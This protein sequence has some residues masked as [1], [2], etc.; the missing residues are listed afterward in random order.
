MNRLFLLFCLFGATTIFAQQRYFVL[1]SATGQ[2]TGLSWN[3]AFTSLTTAFQTAV[4]GDEIWV[5]AGTYK[6]TDGNDRTISFEPKSGVKMYGGFAG[7]ET[8]LAQRDW[9]VNETVLSG[10]I[11]VDQFS[12]DNSY[13]VVYLSY[14]DQNTIMD[15]FTIKS[16]R[17]DA[18]GFPVGSP[19]RKVSGAG[20]YVM[21]ENG[22]A[23]PEFHH[24]KIVNNYAKNHGG[25]VMVN[26]LIPGS[27]VNPYF[28]DCTV[29]DNT[30][31]NKG[32]GIAKWGGSFTDR[33]VD[34]NHCTVENNQAKHAGGVM[35]KS[36]EGFD[37]VGIQH[38]YFKNNNSEGVGALSVEYD[39]EVPSSLYVYDSDFENNSGNSILSISS[40][41]YYFTGDIF[42]SKCNFS[43]NQTTSIVAVSYHAGGDN[44]NV[45]M[46]DIYFNNNLSKER[47][48][49]LN[50]NS[51]WLFFNKIFVEPNNSIENSFELVKFAGENVEVKNSRFLH[52]DTLRT[53]LL[54][55]AAENVRL[56]NVIFGG[57]VLKAYYANGYYTEPRYIGMNPMAD[58]LI[59][60]N[61]VF[62][63]RESVASISFTEG[64]VNMTNS[65]VLHKDIT[66]YNFFQNSNAVH[67]DNNYFKELN[68][69]ELFPS[70]HLTN[71]LIGIDPMLVDPAVYDYHLQPCSPLINAGIA[72]GIQPGDTDLDGN[73]RIIGSNIDIGP[74]ETTTLV[75]PGPGTSTGT[76]AG[77]TNGAYQ[78]EAESCG[79]LT[80][81][82][83]GPNGS[84]GTTLTS[85]APGDYLL[86]VTDNFGSTAAI[87][88]Q[89]PQAPSPDMH[90][91]T[92]PVFCGTTTGGSAIAIPDSGTPPFQFLWENSTVDSVRNNLPYGIYT[93]QL[94]DA[95]GCTTT[96]QA[97]IGRVGNL[98]INL[99]KN[100]PLCYGDA[101]GAIT[102]LPANGAPPYNYTWS[103]GSTGMGLNNLPAGTYYGTMTDALGCGI[104]WS[105][106]LVAPDSVVLGTPLINPASDTFAADGSINLLP[107]GGTAPF[108]AQ[109]SNG[110]TGILLE[111]LMPGTYSVTLTDVNNCTSTATY[112]VSYTVG[113]HEVTM[114]EAK[115]W[116]NPV[117][118]FLQIQ[119]AEAGTYALTISDITGRPLISK[120]V[121]GQS[122]RLEVE[123]L[124][125]GTYMLHLLDKN[126]KR[127][128]KKITVF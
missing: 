5:A 97:T 53:F 127:G 46:R 102:V 55:Y 45:E 29:K 24:C 125:A 117:S 114:L 34:I 90:F 7:N 59:I 36:F 35:W 110:A 38:C 98:M 65:L 18:S 4:S 99:L 3:D 14:P 74:Y 62:D 85:L 72:T 105:V 69:N 19:D 44:N 20:I 60:K 118:S 68:T 63:N 87:N 10:D 57:E 31:L 73:P 26:G 12:G 15:G 33:A 64:A 71:N 22:V 88:F 41:V 49:N 75:V 52:N 103:D 91:Q 8:D 95:A 109:W 21:G 101:N 9:V 112:E 83:T 94:T 80:Y 111:N 108:T 84:T 28:N 13:N 126:G 104:N 76:C 47:V 23:E 27:S 113:N 122:A 89:I 56:D 42:I 120:K 6:P 128:W 54:F 2:N 116:P 81:S 78:P 123:H 50:C 77:G 16:G 121:E 39:S 32:G 82:W 30:A 40:G 79:P 37:S 51:K 92:T 93:V 100:S 86:T 67:L 17:A 124:P 70:F 115:I 106:P 119:F 48:M 61:C 43:E 96:S 1:P 66:S 25:G 58:S 11:G 107:L